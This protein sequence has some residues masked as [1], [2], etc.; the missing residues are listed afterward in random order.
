VHAFGLAKKIGAPR[1]LVPPL[2]G[3]GSALGFFTAP[4]AFD[5]TRSHRVSLESADFG[6]IE[7]LFHSLETEGAAI[8]QK[9]LDDPSLNIE[10]TLMMRFIGQG[11]E[12]DLNIDNRP[13]EQWTNQQIRKHFDDV[14]QKLYGRTYPET[15]IEFVTFK[16]RVSEPQRPFQLPRI[17]SRAGK[18]ADVHKGSRKAFCMQRKAYVPHEVYD[19][20]N[21]APGAH[22]NGPAIIEERESTIIIGSGAAARVDDRGF[23]WIDLEQF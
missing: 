9:S 16:V 11:A 14:Y 5:L 13:F 3:V 15:E 8:L 22:M 4:V 18:A 10:R 20:T 6:E 7:S 21:L 19:R 1:I 23:V 12:T 17:S 2:A